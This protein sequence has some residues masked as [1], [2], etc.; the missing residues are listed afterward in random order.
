MSLFQT[1]P[2]PQ[3]P[4][5]SDFL[6]S[7]G[8][9]ALMPSQ[10]T[11]A[12]LK[13]ALSQVDLDYAPQKYQSQIDLTNAQASHYPFLNALTQA[14][15]QAVPSEIALRMAQ[16]SHY[17]FL[18][19]LTAAQTNMENQLP[20]FKNRE[21]DIDQQKANQMGARFGKVYQLTKMLQS[22][23]APA[24]AT[25]IA[26]NPDAY[27]DLTTTLGNQATMELIN[28]PQAQN[29]N[30]VLSQ[31]QSPQQIPQN[32]I[33]S[34]NMQNVQFQQP[35][36]L[37]NPALMNPALMNNI[38]PQI[39]QNNMPMQM[40]NPQQMPSQI[41]AQFFSTPQSSAD[42]KKA[43]EMEANKKLTT[44]KTNVRNEGGRA[45]E[46]MMQSP[47]VE[48]SF[49]KLSQYSGLMGQGEA[50]LKRL[51][52]PKEFVQIQSAKEQVGRMLAGSIGTLEGYPTSDFGAQQGL[53]FFRMAQ[54]ALV[55]DPAAA[56][57][58]FDLGRQ[59]LKAEAESVQKAA[60]PIF[61]VNNLPNSGGTAS[62]SQG[63][64]TVRLP[65]GSTGQI[66]SSNLQA[67]LARGAQRVG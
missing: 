58:Y 36:A 45:L 2:L 54:Q 12:N 56:K 10:L 28:G 55:N 17:P 21:L 64:V 9:A 4:E 26:N 50:Q 40:Q 66:P 25:Y 67:A 57:Q 63:L 14:Q 65:N 42:L 59:A 22:M 46:N 48:D 30:N 19:A 62:T 51:T 24:R 33:A 20:G 16:A 53:H 1:I 32:A 13:N 23:S 47:I 31:P 27:N 61:D 15:T 60:N 7:F 8:R 3:P 49:N 39:P 11:A 18:N 52:N 35:N 34:Q 41:P 6:S 5:T 38:P 29:Q 37:M 43:S 44:N